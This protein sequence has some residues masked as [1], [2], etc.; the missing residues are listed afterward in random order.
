[1]RVPSASGRFLQ[2]P[3][4]PAVLGD[5]RLEVSIGH[6]V[7]QTGSSSRPLWCMLPQDRQTCCETSPQTAQP[8]LPQQPDTQFRRCG[9]FSGSQLF[10][11]LGSFCSGT[12]GKAE[13]ER[14]DGGAVC[15]QWENNMPCSG[16]T[17]LCVNA[18]GSVTQV[19]AGFAQSELPLRAACRA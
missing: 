8:A 15:S 17:K 12:K 5:L 1:M 4:K 6:S 14:T 10:V 11:V 7:E 16:C 18:A 13:K 2:A 3:R 9:F 19:A